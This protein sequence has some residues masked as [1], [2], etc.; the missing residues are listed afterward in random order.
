M[1]WLAVH[2]PRHPSEPLCANS[3]R[4]SAKGFG[5]Q[6]ASTLGNLWRRLW[7]FR[8]QEAYPCL[9][10]IDGS[11]EHNRRR[12]T[13]VLQPPYL[14]CIQIVEQDDTSIHRA[15]VNISKISI[16]R[17]KPADILRL[18]HLMRRPRLPLNLSTL[19][20]RCGNHNLPSLCTNCPDKLPDLPPRSTYRVGEMTFESSQ[21][22]T[23]CDTFGLAIKS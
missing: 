6:S 14:A 1:L 22:F 9:V 11:F 4:I 18:K 10:I 12:K 7:R 23:F 16:T 13:H 19:R 2:E 3:S 17:L 5:K 8:W 15:N 20:I 21:S